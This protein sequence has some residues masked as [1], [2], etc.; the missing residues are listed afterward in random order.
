MVSSV[1]Q[2]LGLICADQQKIILGGVS[3]GPAFTSILAHMPLAFTHL[4][5][6]FVGLGKRTNRKVDFARGTYASR[7]RSF[8]IPVLFLGLF[9]ITNADVT[10]PPAP[11]EPLVTTL[12]QAVK[13]VTR[14]SGGKILS[15]RRIQTRQGPV[16]RIK[17]LTRAGR[18]RV[19]Q[20]AEFEVPTS[21]TN[22]TKGE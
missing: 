20:I 11:P 15:A 5:D 6:I 3:I 18:V 8:A 19:V 4:F 14:E 2:K 22:V 13:R 9:G 21:K 16:F 1:E 7:I 17:V 12:E 10:T